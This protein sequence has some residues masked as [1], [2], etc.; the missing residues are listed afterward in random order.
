MKIGLDCHVSNEV[1]E[2]LRKFTVVQAED[3]ESDESWFERGKA[4][5]MTHV[6]SGDYD[7]LMLCSGTEIVYIKARPAQSLKNQLRL[8]DKSVG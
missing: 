6:Y 2:A 3:G 1:R 8:I 5:G 7:L 4:Q